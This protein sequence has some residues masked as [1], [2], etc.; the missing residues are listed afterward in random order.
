LAK[1]EDPGY[2]ADVHCYSLAGSAYSQRESLDVERKY[3]LRNAQADHHGK[4]TCEKYE[5]ALIDQGEALAS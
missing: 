1:R 3:R 5:Q 2:Q 4:Q